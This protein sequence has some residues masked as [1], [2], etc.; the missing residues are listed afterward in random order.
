MD[1]FP[2]LPND[3]ASAATV[4]YTMDMAVADGI[5][6]RYDRRAA[7]EGR[8]VG[9]CPRCYKIG[10]YT[11][12]C[13][14]CREEVSIFMPSQMTTGYYLCP[15][16]IAYVRAKPDQPGYFARTRAYQ[17]EQYRFGHHV[18]AG[19]GGGGVRGVGLA[20]VRNRANGLY[21]IFNTLCYSRPP[22]QM[23]VGEVGQIRLLV[24]LCKGVVG[25]VNL[26]QEIGEEGDR[27]VV[28]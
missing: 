7:T 12:D 20:L 1:P 18:W 25:A 27:E 17:G 6:V 19:P 8:M 28:V 22:W 21:S 14:E 5:L 16:M 26:V 4:V 9:N 11:H 15:E 24:Q 13:L 2:L 3:A 23:T 10:V